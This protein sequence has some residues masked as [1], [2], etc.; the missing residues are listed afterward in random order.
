MIDGY[1]WADGL[2]PMFY[3]GAPGRPAIVAAMPPFEEANRTRALVVGVLHLLA[4]EG[5][6]VAIPDLPGAGESLKPTEQA[7][8]AEWRAAFAAAVSAVAQEN[9]RPHI[10]SLRGGAILDVE[11]DAASR[12]RLAPIDGPAIRRDLVRAGMAAAHEAGTSLDPDDLVP[13]GGP[14]LLTGNRISRELLAEL[15]TAS[16]DAGGPLRTLR[17][18]SDPLPADRHLDG[19]ALWRRA[20]PDN[21]EAFAETLAQDVDEWIRSCG[22]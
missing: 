16:L 21:D 14:M 15:E 18:T 12:W 22:A 9:D 1:R 10:L 13:P 2:E 3:L 11:A 8:L 17:L 4:S 20:E 7:S 5:Y 19:P 6:T